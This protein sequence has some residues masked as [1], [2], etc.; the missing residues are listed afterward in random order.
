MLTLGLCGGM[1]RLHEEPFALAQRAFTHDG[2]A[3]LVEDGRVVAA[4]EEER[5][6]R[7][8]HS[9][10]FP[11]LSL[12]QCLAERGVSI[13]DVD[14]IA[15]YATENYCNGMLSW[16]HLH[17][18]GTAPFVPARE[19]LCRMVGAEL[20]AT[21]DPARIVFVPHHVAHAVSTFYMSG[22]DESL[23][24]AIDG[25]GDR[26]SGYVG[27]GQGH[28]RS[29]ETITTFPQTKSLGIFYL[30]VIGFV[31]YSH[32]DEY[33]V[34][35]LAPYGDPTGLRPVMKQLYSLLPDGEYAI[36]FDRLM[37][38]MGRVPVRKKGEP[39]L[40]P[41]M[42]LAAAL[43]E[44]LEDIVMHV[45]THH[46]HK[47]GLRDLCLAGGVAHNC[48][49]NGR[50]LYSGL[51]DR[52]FVQPAAHD[53]GTALGAALFACAEAQKDTRVAP[54]T[55][56]YWGKDLGDEASIA[57]E[58]SAWERFITV[59]RPA[60]PTRAAA[61][62]LAGGA[63]LG[64]VQG[65]SEFGPRALGNRSILADPRPAANKDRI[66][67]MVK[68]RE[69]YR[70]FAPSALEE[71][72]E[73]FFD[74][75]A[76]GARMPY[77]VFVVKVREEMRELL[78]AVTHVDGT[79]RLQTVSREDNPRY[80]ALIRA[81][82]DLT[83]VPVLLNTSFNNNAEPIVD[84][85]R[86]AVV[87]F[88]TTQLDGLVAG[89]FI[90]RKKPFTWRDQLSLVASLPGHVQLCRVK[91]HVMAD[92]SAIH[93]E[94]RSTGDPQLRQ[95]VS[96]AAWSLLAAADGAH[97]IGDLLAAHAPDEAGWPALVEELSA[98]WS[99]RLVTLAPPPLAEATR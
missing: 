7:V 4:S 80:H 65:R 89:D 18:P 15:Y 92:Q 70:P 76:G 81:F 63:V 23:V 34:M 78:G 45:V 9:A 25:S 19:L 55:H 13:H 56:L 61:E 38:L 87:C 83:S 64:W 53:A 30:E 85:V 88:L 39:I 98:L 46:R 71:E 22:F 2:A 58:L 94:L 99:L 3:V 42:D 6:N 91:R 21:I 67:Q 60:D 50:I 11:A 72:A 40:Q 90:V 66:N 32:F 54:L 51:F 27:H 96:G 12:R 74:L 49:M 68:K 52:V 16:M 57:R 47:T 86:D 59:E 31:G 35:G 1:N 62:L 37:L 43:Q 17:S 36:H 5:L 20:G 69:A 29:I 28:G 82:G 48:T 97:T 24:L 44:S 75:P 33:K 73:R 8:K 26:L 84:S 93:A 41:H 95:P 10:K 77:M 14:R 79:A